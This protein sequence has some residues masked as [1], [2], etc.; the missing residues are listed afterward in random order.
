FKFLPE[1]AHNASGE[2]QDRLQMK[3]QQRIE[4]SGEAF[5]TTTVLGGRRAM[6]VN[7]NSFLTERRHVDDLVELL[8]RESKELMREKR[9]S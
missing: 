3:L 6:R 5:I 8:K 7:I 1:T 2:D 9:R 4:R